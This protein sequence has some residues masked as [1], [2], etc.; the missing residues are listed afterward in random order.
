VDSDD[1]P[2]IISKTPRSS[3]RPQDLVGNL[4]GRSLAHFELLEP[5]G[6]GGMAAVLRARDKQLDR[7]VALKIL[8]PEMATDPE[9]V[10][11]FHQEARAA[12]KLDHENIAR[13]FFCGEDQ[14]LHFIAFEFVEGENLR[15][16][17]ERRGRLPVPEAIHYLLQVALGLDHAASR[18]VVHRDVKPSNIIISANGR[19]KLV[20]M[21]LARSLVPHDEKALTQSGVTLG[22]FDYISPEQALEPRQA[23]VRS[24]LYSLGCTGYHMLTG[25]APVPEGTAAKKLHHHQHVA[26]I[27]PRQLNPAIP[28]DVA[29]VLARMMAKDPKDRY[30][31]P[32]H[33]VQHLLQIAQKWGAAPELPQGVLFVD[34]PLPNPPQ[35]RPL[36]MALLAGVALCAL[37]VLLSLAP[38]STDRP[39]LK[40]AGGAA[41]HPGKDKRGNGGTSEPSPPL[42]PPGT[43][44]LTRRVAREQDFVDALADPEVTLIVLEKDLD[45]SHPNIQPP[46]TGKALHI[47]G[48]RKLT[49]QS[50]NAQRPCTLEF[51]YHPSGP[52][53]SVS[54]EGKDGTAWATGL[55]V[56]EGEVVLQNVRLRIAARDVPQSLLAAVTVMRS[57]KLTLKQC[58]F[59]QDIP[60]ELFFADKNRPALVTALHLTGNTSLEGG[61]SDLRPALTAVGCYFA[62][63]EDAVLLSSPADLKMTN[64][65]FGP[66]ASQFHLPRRAAGPSGSLVE[67][68]HCSAFAVSGPIFRLDG[69]AGCQVSAQDCLFS[70]PP[71][72]P[73]DLEAA[74]RGPIPEAHLFWQTGTTEPSVVYK[75]ARNW[76]HNLNF[77][78]RAGAGQ[79]E[80]IGKGE[81]EYARFVRQVDQAGG[82][83]LSSRVLSESPWNAAYPLQAEPARAKFRV[84]PAL[85]REWLAQE[86][87]P[88]HP[89][90][91]WHCVW[92]DTYSAQDLKE[93]IPIKVPPPVVKGKTV[94]PGASESGKGVYPTLVGA[95][96][97]LR[98]E[99]VIWIKHTGRLAFEP[100]KLK[101]DVDVTFKPLPGYHPV[102]TL[103]EK[104]SE[105]EAF[106]FQLLQGKVSFEGLEFLVQPQ[107]PEFISQTVVK[108]VGNGQCSFKNCVVTLTAAED[109][110]LSVVTLAETRELMKIPE[111]RT[112]PEVVFRDCFVRGQGDLAYVCASRPFT[113]DM[114]NALA[115]LTG[116]LVSVG[117]NARELPPGD[118]VAQVKL[119]N[120]TT[121]LT[122]HLLHLRGKGPKELLVTRVDATR[123]LF[124][125]PSAKPLILLEGLEGE[126]Q[127][128]R[129]F[130]WKGGHNA[131]SGYETLLET[132][133]TGEGVR[134]FRLDQAAWGMFAGES[135]P[136]PRF[137]KLKFDF[138]ARIDRSLS[139]VLPGELRVEGVDLQDAG[140]ALEQ[141]PRPWVPEK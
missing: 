35:H 91:V 89:I 59:D 41:S 84:K 117:G 79:T 115:A 102:L 18:G 95:L 140:A 63:G 14:R 128:K 25:Q 28:D 11:R 46:R 97:D 47:S 116:S 65:A 78:V 33:L 13:V 96:E 136:E 71:V 45:L 120:V 29:A 39:P 134:A 73:S 21:G 74:P 17:L 105:A 81:E 101:T 3:A 121:Y 55:T 44:S 138:A 24:D 60:A 87:P 125:G 93:K 66:H 126:E 75:G 85:V 50:S 94:F 82:K 42:V 1:A 80:V 48:P 26:P 38:S 56:E 31:R 57:G 100:I 86:P 111:T 52:A 6:V 124:V 107:R 110:R 141:I 119:K 68:D 98:D 112:A 10:R 118:A 4:R 20:D 92:E 15:T 27:D 30:Q 72:D 104:T 23:D 109:A 54:S 12:A 5:I 139:Q 113:L 76:F 135:D 16:I 40:S 7:I 32:E 90:G 123:N 2:T 133:P 122:E 77:W 130:S 8:P 51:N 9:N 103:S 70:C 67:L 43:T 53:G 99:K 34:A 36:L 61:S 108:L 64:C 19:A 131:Y 62:R 88:L 129:L 114:D 106:L 22:T 83:D 132:Q 69:G 58:A 127:M 37:L 137:L 49:I